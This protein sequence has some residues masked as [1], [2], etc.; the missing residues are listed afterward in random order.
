MIWHLI[1]IIYSFQQKKESEKTE[2]FI[3]NTRKSLQKLIMN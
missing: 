2:V 1:F 3:P